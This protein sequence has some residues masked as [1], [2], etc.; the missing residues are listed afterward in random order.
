[1]ENSKSNQTKAI[2]LKH[3]HQNG[4]I[5]FNYWMDILY[6]I[7]K[8]ISSKKYLIKDVKRDPSTRI[9]VNKTE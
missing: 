5:N 3:Q 7:F 9:Y 4:R 6:Q 2:N 8:F 1:M